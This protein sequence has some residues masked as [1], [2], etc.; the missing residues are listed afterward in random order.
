MCFNVGFKFFGSVIQTLCCQ[1]SV[2]LHLGV[3][4]KSCKRRRLH[5]DF[6]AWGIDSG[7]MLWSR[8]HTRFL[9]VKA[10]VRTPHHAVLC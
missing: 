5:V 3:Q 10:S 9:A 6:G 2:D 7:V 1:G 4:G 8:L